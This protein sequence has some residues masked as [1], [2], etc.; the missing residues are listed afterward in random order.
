MGWSWRQKDARNA[1][2]TTTPG[3]VIDLPKPPDH[4]IVD[5]KPIQGI[6]WPQGLNLS[7]NSN[8]IWIP[9]K[10]TSQCE[11]KV[12]VGTQESVT[13]CA[14]AVDLAF[15]ISIWKCQGGIFDYI[16]ALLEHSPG[17]PTLTFEK[18]YAMF[19]RVKMTCKF[20]CLPLSPAFNKAKLYNLQAERGFAAWAV[21]VGRTVVFVRG[22][23]KGA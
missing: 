14:H 2:K 7:L 23:G 18:L 4:I 16:I 6:K 21:F 13:Y 12:K 20:W 1:I 17:S 15:A 3:Q 8:L 11:K 10:L 5:I 9:I 19:T 22:K